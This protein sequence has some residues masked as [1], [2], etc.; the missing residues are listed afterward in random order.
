MK[1]FFLACLLLATGFCN[2]FAELDLIPLPARIEQQT[3]YFMLD[4]RTVIV[5]DTL[6]TNEAALIADE[7]H[8]TNASNADQNRI[9]LTTNHAEGLGTEAYRLEVD[10]HG[11]T[12]H[13]LYPAGAFYGCQTLRQL[14]QP[15]TKEIPFVKIEDAPRY[16]W[17]GLMLDV[18]R[19]FFDKPTILQLLDSMADYKLNR[20]H[21]HLTDD[22]AWRLDIE[23]YPE[24][25]RVGARGNYSDSNAPPQF[26]TRAQMREIIEYAARRHIIVVPEIDM[27][28][29]AGAAVR[30]YP[31]LDGGMHTFNPASAETCDFLQDVL[32]E[33]MEIFPSQWIHL[34]GDEVNRSAWKDKADV[35]QRM[36][37][38]GVTNTQELEDYFVNRMAGFVTAHGRTPMGWD[39]IVA[40]KPRADTVIFWWRHDKPAILAQA[41]SAGHP[42]VLTPRS[43]CYFDYP[44]DKTYPQIGW[45]LFNTPE[46][47]YQ[48]PAIPATISAAERKQILGVEACIWTERI[49]TVSYLQ[50]MAN[51]RMAALAEMAWTPD[52]DRNFAQFDARLKPF[53]RQYQQLGVHYYDENDPV[54]SLRSSLQSPEPA[55]QLSLSRH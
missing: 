47:V 44:Q 27:P 26:F 54:G 53:L 11:V 20:L 17:R 50:F 55:Q 14:V 37:V 9:L 46:A 41:L 22:Q 48:G 8:V 29:H 6:F 16:G 5:A 43:P 21:L 42:V 25:A 12:I 51:P 36:R 38:G 1:K 31:Q 39:E 18:S 32:T 15:E 40:A 45:K 23:K 10:R 33:T 35:L 30:A 2:G 7:Q 49:P 3:G 4:S 52:E 28:G 34:G 13:A 19:H 24:L